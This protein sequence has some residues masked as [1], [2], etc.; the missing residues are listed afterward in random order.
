M[1]DKEQIELLRAALQ[2]I[3]DGIPSVNSE[4]QFL[5]EHFDMEGNY[6]G[7]EFHDPLA[8]IQS[9]VGVAHE[10]LAATAPSVQGQE[11]VDERQAFEDHIRSLNPN[12]LFVARWPEKD[13]TGA[14][15]GAYAGHYKNGSVDERWEGWLARA[16]LR[17]E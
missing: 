2:K 14:S 15:T 7:T 9:I 12:M 3:F 16:A 17:S 8:I 10:A 5:T 13:F 6:A 4:G 11:K 1:T